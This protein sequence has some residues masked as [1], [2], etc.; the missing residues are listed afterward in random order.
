MTSWNSYIR[1]SRPRVAGLGSY[2][3]SL[4]TP[5]PNPA[6]LL[7][8][9]SM[10]GKVQYLLSIRIVTVCRVLDSMGC[11]CKYDMGLTDTNTSTYAIEYQSL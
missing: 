7:C 9:L 11:Y 4:V 3:I 10:H 6:L 2:G 1:Y 8:M 5:G